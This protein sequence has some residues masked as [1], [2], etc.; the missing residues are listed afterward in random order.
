MGYQD[1]WRLGVDRFAAMV[2]AHDL[3]KGVPVL[4]VGVG[5]AL[6]LDLLGARGRHFGGAIIPA[7]QLMI[8]TLLQRLP[9]YSAVPRV[10]AAV[11]AGCLRAPP[12]MR[13]ARGRSTLR[14]HSSTVRW[15][16]VRCW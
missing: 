1:P 12:A 15:M 16:T 4:V 6:T 9:G 2:G 14:R 7:P 11:R 3:F 5:T 10:A 13:S 8:A